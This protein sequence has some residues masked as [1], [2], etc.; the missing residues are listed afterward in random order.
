MKFAETELKGVFVVDVEPR[1]DERGFLAVGFNREEFAKHGLDPNVVQC[2]ITYNAKRGTLRGM[3]FQV[4]PHEQPKL[5]RCVRGSVFD[6]AVDL[7][8]ESPT[9]RKWVGYDLTAD[10]RRMLYI[11]A[12]LAHGFVT[13]EDDT[14]VIYQ[15]SEVYAPESARGVRW[16][17]PAFG[18][19]WPVKPVVVNERDA[20]YPD[21]KG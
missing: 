1:S 10:N 9:F 16:N 4:K 15:M 12:G 20:S 8:P 5:V 21:F 14:E 6:V 2:N 17:D 19:K 18:I 11:P 13:L 7:R 3:H